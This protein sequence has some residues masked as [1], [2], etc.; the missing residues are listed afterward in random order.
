MVDLWFD[1]RN[2]M[3]KIVNWIIRWLVN[4]IL[5][6]ILQQHLTERIGFSE[7]KMEWKSHYFRTKK[8]VLPEVYIKIVIHSFILILY[9]SFTI[10]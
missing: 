1:S 7:V 4:F 8:K 3:V 6:I 10:G 5:P 9:N 2:M